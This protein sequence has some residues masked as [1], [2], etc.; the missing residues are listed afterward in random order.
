MPLLSCV[1]VQDTQ[2]A[3]A[4]GGAQSQVGSTEVAFSVFISKIQGAL[5]CRQG[6]KFPTEFEAAKAVVVAL[7]P[8]ERVQFVT[9]A[10]Q[11]R[12]EAKEAKKARGGKE[13]GKKGKGGKGNGGGANGYNF[14][15]GYAQAKGREVAD[16]GKMKAEVRVLWHVFS[17][18][19]SE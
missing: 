5:S 9:T 3:G 8:G 13:K 7:L 1:Q 18:L 12:D 19:L 6:K 2:E 4:A 15:M 16:W 14:W 17:V 11:L 10:V